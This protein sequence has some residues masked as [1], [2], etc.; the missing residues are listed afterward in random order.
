MRSDHVIHVGKAVAG[1]KEG[2]KMHQQKAKETMQ[3]MEWISCMKSVCRIE[4]KW[5]VMYNIR[6][7]IAIAI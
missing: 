2:E 6:I 1:H 7:T 3:V 5:F 4:S